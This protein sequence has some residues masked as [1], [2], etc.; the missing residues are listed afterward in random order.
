[1]AEPT[2]VTASSADRL[3]IARERPDRP[4]VQALV[5]ASHAYSAALYPAESN[6]N[7]ALDELLAPSVTFLVARLEGEAVGCGALA[8]GETGEAE[9]KTMWVSPVRRGCGIG[10]RLLERLEAIGRERGCRWLRLETGIRQPE[11]LA[12]Y[13]GAGFVETGPFGRYA[14]DPLSVFMAKALADHP[15]RP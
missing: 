10:R 4:D 12:L 9:L 7:L 1:M 15:C 13:R 3:T 14:P 11:A 8:L 5:E 6:H 2:P